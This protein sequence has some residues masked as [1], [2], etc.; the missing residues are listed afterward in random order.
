MT[1]G[2]AADGLVTSGIPVKQL[3]ATESYIKQLCK[4]NNHLFA[5]AV[6]IAHVGF[7]AE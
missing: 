1:S 6:E 4:L 5:L 7:R 2:T 3:R